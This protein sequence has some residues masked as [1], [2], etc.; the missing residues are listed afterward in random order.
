[1]PASFAAT[2]DEFRRLIDYWE[3][4]SVGNGNAGSVVTPSAKALGKRKARV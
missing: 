1:M 4:L 2:V 3:T